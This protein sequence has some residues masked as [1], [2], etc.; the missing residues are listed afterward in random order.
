MNS[1]QV[2]LPERLTSATGL[3]LEAVRVDPSDRKA[4]RIL[5]R[6]RASYLEYTLHELPAGVLYGHN[7]A[8]IAECDELVAELAEFREHVEILGET[9]R[10]AELIGDCTLHFHRYREYLASGRAGGSYKQFLADRP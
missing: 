6:H 8:T 2:A 3:L 1:K 9:P 4:R 10:F 5:V 7:A